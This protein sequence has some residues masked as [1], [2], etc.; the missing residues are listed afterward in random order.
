MRDAGDL[1]IPTT[2]PRTH[3]NDLPPPRHAIDLRS[4]DLAELSSLKTPKT[5]S[6][7]RK[8]S[9]P[10]QTYSSTSELSFTSP[11]SPATPTLTASSLFSP[12]TDSEAHTPRSGLGDGARM[13]TGIISSFNPLSRSSLQGGASLY[14]RSRLTM[15]SKPW[16]DDICQC[17][18]N[19]PFALSTTPEPYRIP[20]R[21]TLPLQTDS[22]YRLDSQSVKGDDWSEGLPSSR[23]RQGWSSRTD[24]RVGAL[25]RP[26]RSN[27][28]PSERNSGLLLRNHTHRH[29]LS[30]STNSRGRRIGG[31]LDLPDSS[32]YRPSGGYFFSTDASPVLEEPFDARGSKSLDYIIGLYGDSPASRFESPIIR[33]S[34]NEDFQP[35]VQR[36]VSTLSLVC[37]G[38]RA[39]T[40]E[41]PRNE[42]AS[43]SNR[44]GTSYMIKGHSIRYSHPVQPS[45]SSPQL[46]SNLRS[47]EPFH[48]DPVTLTDDSWSK[49]IKPRPIVTTS[50]K[51]LRGG[52]QSASALP[53]V[54]KQTNRD[55]PPG[56]FDSDDADLLNELLGYPPN[57]HSNSSNSQRHRRERS[58]IIR[59]TPKSL[60]RTGVKKLARRLPP[61]KKRYHS[62]TC[63][64]EILTP[65]TGGSPPLE[66]TQV[67][68]PRK[69]SQS[70]FGSDT[71]AELSLSDAV[72]EE[73]GVHG[74]GSFEKAVREDESGDL[75]LGHFFQG[76]DEAHFD[77]EDLISPVRDCVVPGTTVKMNRRRCVPPFP[78]VVHHTRLESAGMSASVGGR[79]AESGYVVNFVSRVIR[80]MGLPNAR[81]ST[82]L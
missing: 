8:A 37:N 20:Q 18:D 81:I 46:T 28:L 57:T 48:S 5:P 56:A 1:K 82:K 33:A 19:P 35:L 58:G 72:D 6:V 17:P 62:T 27:P 79:G 69:S 2:P 38:R 70:S 32:Q 21:P 10:D 80:L 29:A 44:Y 43:L 34:D 61:L 71:L 23:A 3:A 59:I 7:R 9:M 51:F 49:F 55:R 52:W 24:D 15:T 63:S 75:K 76:G 22:L 77:E 36:E 47:G 42:G 65:T 60:V 73:H 66:S 12:S 39:D 78:V 26:I 31:S 54:L 14:T 64:W 45:Q 74:R 16:A 53:I 68:V 30:R 11:S 25:M 13:S 4:H 67:P 41:A 50:A 40:P